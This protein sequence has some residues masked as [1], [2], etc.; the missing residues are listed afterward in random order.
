MET[1]DAFRMEAFNIGSLPRPY[2]NM[3]Y[4][5]AHHF[6]GFPSPHVFD[7]FSERRLGFQ[8]RDG[9]IVIYPGENVKTDI[10]IIGDK[11][12]K[13]IFIKLDTPED[14]VCEACERYLEKRKN[15]VYPLEDELGRELNP[16]D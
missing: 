10:N 15:Q 16:T 1:S 13:L 9:M 8:T 6:V 3:D 2:E 12:F 5:R 7:D 4:S 14:D 11:I